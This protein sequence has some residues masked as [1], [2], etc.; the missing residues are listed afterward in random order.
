M[1]K[2]F[3]PYEQAKALKDLGFNEE[4]LGF[5]SKIHG[6]YL[7]SPTKVVNKDAGEY[8]A[9]LYQQ[10]FRWFRKKHNM[11]SHV[12]NDEHGYSYIIYKTGGKYPFTITQSMVKSHEKAELKCLKKLIELTK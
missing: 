12:E 9:P 8:L 5:H 10:A 2:E 7:S 3:I 6:L 1:E 11:Q 4:C